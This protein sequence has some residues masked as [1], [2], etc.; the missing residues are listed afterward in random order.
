MVLLSLMPILVGLI[1]WVSAWYQVWLP[2]AVKSLVMASEISSFHP[3]RS[4][5]R[6][7][8]PI[9]LSDPFAPVP[10]LWQAG[11]FAVGTAIVLVVR[12]RALPHLR[13]L[14]EVELTQPSALR[15]WVEIS[16]SVDSV[17]RLAFPRLS[18]AEIYESAGVGNP[19]LDHI[20]YFRLGSPATW[21][22]SA[23]LFPDLLEKSVPTMRQW[24]H[25]LNER[26]WRVRRFMAN[27]GLLVLTVYVFDRLAPGGHGFHELTAQMHHPGWTFAVF[28]G[29]TVLAPVLG[30]AYRLIFARAMTNH[31]M[32]Q[33]PSARMISAGRRTI[34]FWAWFYCAAW[35]GVSGH[36]LV[37]YP[38]MSPNEIRLLPEAPIVLAATFFTLAA[39]LQAGYRPSWWTWAMTF[40]LSSYWA[41]YLPGR[42]NM[43]ILMVALYALLA[44]AVTAYLYIGSATEDFA[45]EFWP[46]PGG[47]ASLPWSA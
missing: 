3:V 25:Y 20:S 13:R 12:W 11:V 9:S 44:G 47:L 38:N 39:A 5:W 35:V 17:G 34:V 45:D 7:F 23:K 18:G 19:A 30:F 22:I 10:D 41:S 43:F 16:S 6:L 36:F 24:T 15:R 40:A 8:V 33:P 42:S 46:I 29:L 1:Q 4:D 37:R 27:L 26:A 14:Q 28:L 31:P 32:E 2:G 21:F